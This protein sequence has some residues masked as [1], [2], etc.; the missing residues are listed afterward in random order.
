MDI[1][2]TPLSQLFARLS[3]STAAKS[4]AKP[5]PK[6]KTPYK[7]EPR[8]PLIFRTTWT[9]QA[10]VLIVHR[11]TCS[12]CSSIFESPNKVLLR[13]SSKHFATHCILPEPGSIYPDLP[14]LTEYIA[15]TV[16]AC[17]HC[18][19]LSQIIH[20]A[21]NAPRQLP[22]LTEPGQNQ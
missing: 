2:N 8:P 5:K 10:L 20:L 15:N 12:T 7:A 9:N 16:S 17:Q 22:L 19:D 6:P 1:A 18:F 14:L 13:R 11:T 4:T 21:R 3:Q